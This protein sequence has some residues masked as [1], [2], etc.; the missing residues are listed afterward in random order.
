MKR[1]C[2]R[3]AVL[4]GLLASL[5][6]RQALAFCRA[7]TCDHSL[8]ACPTD[9]LGCSS[10]GTPLAWS[11]SCVSLD[12]SAAG[13]PKLRISFDEVARATRQA[14]EAWTLADCGRE[15]HPTL[16]YSVNSLAGTAPRVAGELDRD[17]VVQFRDQDWPYHNLDSS[18]ALTT[19]TFVANTGEIIDADIEINSHARSFNAALDPAA[20]DLDAVLLHEVGHLL[21]LGHSVNDGSAMFARYG[22]RS[23]HSGVLSF[24]D[25]QAVCAAY[26]PA[27]RLPQ[28]TLRASG[29]VPCKSLEGCRLVAAWFLGACWAFVGALAALRFR[30]AQRRRRFRLS[31]L[32]RSAT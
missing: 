20:Y 4:L 13:S 16:V 9:E 21:G 30:H 14:L 25:E 11:G 31:A 10:T 3:L 6:S 24:D 22:G 15:F 7:T 8:Y 29:W 17:N 2:A 32:N 5:V 1:Q 12:V 27:A 26:P 19:L 18:L 23:E 28:C